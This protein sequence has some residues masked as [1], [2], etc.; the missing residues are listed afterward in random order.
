MWPWLS[1][2]CQKLWFSYTSF[3]PAPW[4]LP[5]RWIALTHWLCLHLLELS[6][7]GVSEWGPR[8]SSIS[9]TG[10]LV[11][12]ANAQSEQMLKVKN[13]Q[14]TGTYTF[15]PARY[16]FLYL[17]CHLFLLSHQ[18]ISFYHSYPLSYF[19]SLKDLPKKRITFCTCW[20]MFCS[21]SNSFYFSKFTEK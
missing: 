6:R 13:Q 12:N 19:F 14:S 1:H 17:E 20:I 10:E 4:M 16:T 18:I 8:T 21:N 11:R 3:S 2:T 9:V 7:A 5:P 15:L